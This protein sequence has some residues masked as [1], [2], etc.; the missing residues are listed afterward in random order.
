MLDITPQKIARVILKA[1]EVESAGGRRSGTWHHLRDFIAGLNED[2]QAS[3]TAVMW[4]GR[5]SFA[6]D[7]LGEAIATARA[8]K[9]VPTEDYLLG[10]PSLADYLE[11]GMEALGLSPEEAED[12][13]MGRG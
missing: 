7:E 3:L 12:E 4:I 8:E 1:R 9:T 13:V 5:D 2:E 10:D 6:P 11:G